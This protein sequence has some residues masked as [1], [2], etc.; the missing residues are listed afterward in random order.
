MKITEVRHERRGGFGLYERGGVLT[1][2]F[3]V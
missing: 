2:P 3:I 1:A